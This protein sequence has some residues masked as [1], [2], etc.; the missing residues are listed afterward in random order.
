MNFSIKIKFLM[1]CLA[2]LVCQLAEA[3]HFTVK[4]KNEVTVS[5]YAERLNDGDTIVLNLYKFGEFAQH[6]LSKTTFTT[7]ASHRRFHIS[8]PVSAR[9]RY[10]DLILPAGT[11]CYFA[12]YLV[13]AGDQV[14]ISMKQ[15]QVFFT[16][17]GSA[18]WKVK[19]KSDSLQ[20]VFFREQKGIPTLES[21]T[22]L[23]NALTQA[24]LATLKADSIRLPPVIYHI[25][26]A[27]ILGEEMLLAYNYTKT[28]YQ[29]GGTSR[30]AAFNQSVKY[31]EEAIGESAVYANDFIAGQIARYKLDSCIIP[32]QPFSLPKAY[33]FFKTG[34]GFSKSLKEK[35]ITYLLFMERTSKEIVPLLADASA[36]VTGGDM[37]KV[38]E[39]LST[40]VMPGARAY[41]FSLPDTAGKLVHSGDFK[42]KVV[43]MDFWFTGCG[44]CLK[45]KPELEKIEKLYQG[46][47]VV[48]ISVGL[49][50]SKTQWLSSVRQN[51]YSTRQSKNLFTESQAFNHPIAR[52]YN[53][54]GCPTLILVDRNG[55]I[56]RIPESPL[57]DGGNG[58]VNAIN[59]TLR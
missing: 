55:N 6:P 28:F 1:T 35:L 49:D 36:F 27:D 29:N 53:I 41:D 50:K 46:K 18:C 7:V 11:G 8:F 9:A 32:D 31:A 5:G 2:L 54:T 33:A 15:Q 48:F 21:K 56:L 13:T 34:T 22:R 4:Q 16:G 42:D 24:R 58:L 40:S 30:P 39:E 10:V 57:D 3:R 20:K 17:Q 37:A 52:H 26:K 45:I 25:L 38:L 23:I 47:D 43:L 44:A 14:N 19:F 59:E 51:K 12:G